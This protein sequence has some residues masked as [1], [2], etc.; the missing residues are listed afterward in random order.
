MDDVNFIRLLSNHWEVFNTSVCAAPMSTKRLRFINSDKNAPNTY[1]INY[2]LSTIVEV[3]VSFMSK[4]D[5]AV[6]CVQVIPFMSQRACCVQRKWFSKLTRLILRRFVEN[7]IWHFWKRMK[8]KEKKEEAERQRPHF[9]PIAFVVVVMVVG[10]IVDLPLFIYRRKFC[11]MTN[12][13]RVKNS[14]PLSLSFSV[15][16]FCCRTIVKMLPFAA[17][18]PNIHQQ[19]HHQSIVVFIWITSLFTHTIYHKCPNSIQFHKNI[20]WISRK[21]S[22]CVCVINLS[23]FKEPKK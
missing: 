5:T 18:K 2:K 7:T 17:F 13:T 8:R 9:Y 20:S 10:P 23:S 3:E 4:H 11:R 12:V 21:C 16:P 19:H 15:H 6:H 14:I 22:L 1:T